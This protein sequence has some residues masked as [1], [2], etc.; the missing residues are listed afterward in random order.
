MTE[1]FFR[2]VASF[3]DVQRFGKLRF[4]ELFAGSGDTGKVGTHLQRTVPERL[5]NVPEGLRV[6]PEG[7]RVVPEEF[8][9]LHAAGLQ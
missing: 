4:A 1:K 9:L 6:V 5:R 7:F 8:R 2:H 3:L